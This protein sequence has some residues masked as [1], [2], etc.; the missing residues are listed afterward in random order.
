MGEPARRPAV[1]PL[2]LD[3]V[4]II[5]ACATGCPASAVWLLPPTGSPRRRE[6]AAAAKGESMVHRAGPSSSAARVT[7]PARAAQSASS[8]AR[9]ICSSG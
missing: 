2:P 6:V 3:A 4:A 1:T 7:L 9:L 8:K 5:A